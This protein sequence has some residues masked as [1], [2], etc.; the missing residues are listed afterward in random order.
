MCDKPLSA[1]AYGA[2]APIG[3]E[4]VICKLNHAERHDMMGFMKVRLTIQT[5]VQAIP[6]NN[7]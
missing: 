4:P 7:G 5:T 2:C 6:A 3:H 1:T